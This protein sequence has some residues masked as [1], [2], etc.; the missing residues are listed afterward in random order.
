MISSDALDQ[1]GMDDPR[2][3][4]V[5][6]LIRVTESVAHDGRDISEHL[7]ELI[8]REDFLVVVREGR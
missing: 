2:L 1:S 5:P 6:G 4:V 8:G 7:P 3:C